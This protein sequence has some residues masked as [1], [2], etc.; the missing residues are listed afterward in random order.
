MSHQLDSSRR[1]CKRNFCRVS[2][3]IKATA[4]TPINGKA[5]SRTR[6]EISDRATGYGVNSNTK[7]KEKKKTALTISAK[8]YGTISIQHLPLSNHSHSSLSKP[9]LGLSVGGLP[10]CQTTFENLDVGLQNRYFSRQSE[11]QS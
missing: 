5:T 4:A 9:Q 2:K 3:V 11:F 7:K 1:V 6:R 8:K 10:F